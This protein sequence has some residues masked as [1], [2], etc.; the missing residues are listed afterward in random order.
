MIDLY[1]FG[2]GNGWRASIAL[3]ECGLPYR[4]HKV[5]I[6][7]GEQNALSFREINPFGK[8][9][10]IVDSDGSRGERITINESGAILLYCAEKA[11]RFVPSDPVKRVAALSW[12][13]HA[14]SDAGEPIAAHF[15]LSRLPQKPEG[16]LAYYYDRLRSILRD[17]DAHLAD[18]EYLVSDISIADLAF[19]TVASQGKSLVG[20]DGLIHLQ[21]WMDAMGAR[22]GVTRGMGVPG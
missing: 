22:P 8:I 2:T 7:R 12:V 17:V 1:T 4:S 19:Y 9:P 6:A 5:N 10:V 21:R 11:G 3:E 14:V 13:F 15:R 18:L 20:C 16:A